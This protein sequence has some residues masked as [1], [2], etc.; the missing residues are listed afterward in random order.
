MTW[1]WAGLRCCSYYW[2]G[3]GDNLKDSRGQSHT[4]DQEVFW[5]NHDNRLTGPSP[6]DTTMTIIA[7]GL[8][9]QEPPHTGY[10]SSPPVPEI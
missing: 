6:F 1:S 10:V 9:P 7:C 8:T 5:G 4:G 3:L 2:A